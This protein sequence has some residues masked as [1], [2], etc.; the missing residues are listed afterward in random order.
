MLFSFEQQALVLFCN[1]R[2]STKTH[3]Q[4]PKRNP[5]EA[6]FI[7]NTFQGR[8]TRAAAPQLRRP[9]EQ[10]NTTIIREI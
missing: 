7:E 4:Q 3:I 2:P 5:K 1:K 10:E 9:F 8:V 6:A